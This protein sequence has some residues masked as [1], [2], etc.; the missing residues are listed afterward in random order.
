[1][2]RP[3]H[4][5]RREH[6]FSLI[7]SLVLLLIMTLVAL[8]GMRSV[9]LD[10][11]MSA[12]SYDRS[13]ALQAAETALR[14]AEARAVASTPGDFPAAGCV[15]GFCAQPAPADAARWTNEA[16]A[17]WRNATAAV[18]ANATTPGA[19]VEQMGDGEN[20]PGCA[21]LIPPLPN[22]LSPRFRVS[23]RSAGD[24]RASVILQS[25]VAIP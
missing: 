23:S 9:A 21:Q 1:M 6:G 12:A 15:D 7:V 20:D 3:R 13:L 24:G 4:T 2:N 18:S 10:S 8:A 25:D 16:F 22:C 17:G 14:E 5:R 19:I 11:T